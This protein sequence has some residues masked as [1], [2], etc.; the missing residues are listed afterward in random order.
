MRKA[1]SFL[2]ALIVLAVAFQSFFRYQYILDRAR[3]IRVDRLTQQT[4]FVRDAIA[5]R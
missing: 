1:G 2:G 4:C 3:L 5:A